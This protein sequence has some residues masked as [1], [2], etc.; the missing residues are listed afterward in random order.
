MVFIC[1]VQFS[2][3]ILAKLFQQTKRKMDAATFAMWIADIVPVRLEEKCLVLGVSENVFTDWLAN[4]YGQLI[5]DTAQEE[6]G[7]KLK[8]CFERL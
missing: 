4:N 7:R 1:K 8:I 2:K 5:A 6:C 3:R